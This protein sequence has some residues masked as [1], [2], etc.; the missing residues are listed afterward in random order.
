MTEP[1]PPTARPIMAFPPATPGAIPPGPRRAIPRVKGPG[2]ARQGERLGPRFAALQDAF[3]A[4]RIRD[5]TEQSES[6]PELVVVFELAGD[7]EG[8]ARA[9]RRVPGLELLA[10]LAD[11]S[12]EPDDDFHLVDQNGRSTAAVPQTLYL[13]MTNARAVA[14]LVRLFERWQADTTEKF[15][16]GLNPWRQVFGQLRSVRRWSAQ[17]RV[18]D[19]GLLEVWRETVAVVGEASSAVRVEID[20]GFRGEQASR[21]AGQARVRELVEQG[22]G[23]VIHQA[24]VAPARFQGLLAELPYRAVEQVLEQGPEAIDLLTAD[25]VMFVAPV[26]P[27]ALQPGVPAQDTS[28]LEGATRPTPTS[29]ARPRVAVF[30]GLPLANHQLLR[31]R[32]IIDDPDVRASAYTAGEQHHGTAVSSLICH[33]DLSR[34]GSRSPTGPIYLRPILQ[35]LPAH[36]GGVEVVID[37]ELLIDVIHR[38]FVRM[39]DGDGS[40]P[41]VAPSVRIVNLSIG[42]PARVFVRDLSPLARLL[43]WLAYRYNLLIVVSAGNHPLRVQVSRDALADPERAQKEILDELAAQA[44]ARKVLAPAEAVNVLTVG[45]LHS[46][47]ADTTL[48][49][50]VLDIIADGLP[51]LY[52]PAGFGHARSVKPELHVAGGRTILQRPP[53]GDPA[54]PVNLVAAPSSARGPG[55]RVAAP[56]AVGDVTATSYMQGTSF[57]AALLTREGDAIM[58]WLS[59][60]AASA[61]S[62]L[63]PV[64]DEQYHPVLAKTLLAHSASWG[65]VAS[66]LHPQP[67]SSAARRQL[68]Q[69]L[70]YGT[71]RADRV[72]S[73]ATNRAVLIGAGTITDGQRHHYQFPLPPSLRAVTDWRRLTLTLGWLSPVAPGARRHRLARLRIHPPTTELGVH[74]VEAEHHRVTNGTLQHEVLEGDDAV[75]FVDEATLTLDIDARVDGTETLPVRYALAASIEVAATTRSNVHDEVRQGLLR[76]RQRQQQQVRT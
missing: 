13:A 28:V 69:L 41:A 29:G 16:Q 38:S 15:A 31:Q 60:A 68:T 50:T 56:S 9:V 66:A 35:P 54:E 24:T 30:D 25:D 73:A 18:R 49:D 39:F 34:P 11:N 57:A 53:P 14:E 42:D 75:A 27:M 5:D 67:T 59:E 46:D 74:R 37:D 8:F 19:T 58:E 72:N 65:E 33:G 17:D 22:G 40:Q 23:R 45:A 1:A 47:S 36:R 48:P 20:L 43:D 44:R 70:G 63:Y 26:R 4:G 6:D 64:P 12:A 10:D 3:A 71:L 55:L 21:D 62:D 51:A 52:T 2:S 7:V 61:E 32:L 76:I